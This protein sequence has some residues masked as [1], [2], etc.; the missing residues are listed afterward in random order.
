MIPE[1]QNELLE[2][3]KKEGFVD[4]RI[5]LN[6]HVEHANI[7]KTHGFQSGDTHGSNRGKNKRADEDSDEALGVEDNEDEEVE[8]MDHGRELDK[9]RSRKRRRV[10]EDTKDDEGV[11]GEAGDVAQ[12]GEEYEEEAVVEEDKASAGSPP[13]L[14]SRE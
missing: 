7:G 13:L 6:E 14:G 10:A 12:Q 11:E 3:A 4:G 2:A 5:I 8:D 9:D 1:E